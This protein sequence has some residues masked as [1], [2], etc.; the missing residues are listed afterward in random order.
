MGWFSKRQ[1]KVEVLDETPV[2]IPLRLTR[3][4]GFNDLVRAMIRSEELRKAAEASGN[5]TFDEADD[6]DVGDDFDPTSP[7]EESFDPL[8]AEI[9][10]KLQREEFD[11]MVE[12]RLN[13]ARSLLG[14]DNGSTSVDERRM[15]DGDDSARRSNKK[16][17]GKS[18]SE[19]NADDGRSVSEADSG[20]A[21]S[22][23]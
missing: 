12:A 9:R 11:A 15:A 20:V 19:Q 1:R 4:S 16:R 2:S 7:Y 18:G 13:K 8:E 5:E 10:K 3:E 22:D 14:V 6:F 21:R 17:K 23:E